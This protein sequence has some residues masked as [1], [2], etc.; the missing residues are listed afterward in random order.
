MTNSLKFLGIARRAGALEIGEKSAETAIL[1]GK[2][3][4]LLLAC[5]ISDNSVK[6]V[7]RLSENKGNVP[8]I[9]L[10][11]SKTEL[12]CAV[13]RGTPGIIAVI[14]ANF[15]A[16]IMSKFAAEAH[17]M[18]DNAADADSSEADKKRD[19]NIASSIG[20]TIKGSKGRMK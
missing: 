15:A 16:G 11:Y 6:K 4:A 12:G 13:G 1:S 2:A 20:K 3:S 18:C 9:R 7:I 8:V 14:D 5:D 19:G 10:K 17:E